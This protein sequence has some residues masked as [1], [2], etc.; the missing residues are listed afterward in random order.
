MKSILDRLR[1]D[2]TLAGL[3]LSRDKRLDVGMPLGLIPGSLALLAE[4][5]ERP[6]VVVTPTGRDGEE[7]VGA[8]AAY[9]PR[10]EVEFFPSW[11]TLPHERLSPRAD[12][13][14]TRLSVLRRLAHPEEFGKLSVVVVPIRAHRG[15]N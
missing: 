7:L 11:E 13:V 10:D 1:H 6:I 3:P 4:D 5:G 12:T 15:R 8:L 2:E 9:L 14:A